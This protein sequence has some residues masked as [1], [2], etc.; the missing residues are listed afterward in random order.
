MDAAGILPQFKGIAVHDHWSS[1]F[2]YEQPAHALCN[3]HHLRELAFIHEQRKEKWAKRMKDQLLLVRCQ[4]AEASERG[5]SVLSE[6]ALLKVE[7]EYDRIVAAGLKYHSRL[8]PLPKGKTGRHKQRD[9][10]NLLDRLLG[11]RSCV[12]RFMYD[13]AV[14]FTNNKSEHDIRMVK[15]KQKISGCFRDLLGG[16]IFC[17]IRSYISTARK[18]G[19]DIWGA[20]ACAIRGSPSPLTAVI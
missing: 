3:A 18:R 16:Q 7:K 8:P 4:V 20:L 1:Y 5:E 12:L 15:L 14:P 2:L 11:Q 9:G 6:S 19:W 17:R 10:K 13:F